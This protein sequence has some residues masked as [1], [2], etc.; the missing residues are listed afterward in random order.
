M[1]QMTMAVLVLRTYCNIFSASCNK[2]P[3]I[4]KLV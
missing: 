3:L 1:I 2:L 4:Y